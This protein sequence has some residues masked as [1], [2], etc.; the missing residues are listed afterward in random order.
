[1]FEGL[2]GLLLVLGGIYIV[3]KSKNIDI[4]IIDYISGLFR[5]KTMASGPTHIMFCFVD[6]YEPQWAIKDDIDTERKRVD[7]W[8]VDY[9]KLC[10]K[11]VD[12]DGKYPQHSFFYPEEEYREEHLSKLA[13]L[14]KS[15]YGEV[16]IHLHHDNDTSDNLR[17]TLAGFATLLQEQHGLLSTIPETKQPAYAFIH[18]NWCLCNARKDGRWCGVNDELVILK[19][20]GCYA[21]FTLP[22]APNES[23]TAKINS[24]YYAKD[25]SGQSKSHNS[26]VDVKVGGEPS[27]DLMVIQGPLTLNWKQRKF[28]FM[29]RIE[30]GDMRG[31]TPPSKERVDLWVN[32]NIH[33]QGRPEWL[34]VKIHTHGTQEQD[35]E[36]LLGRPVDEMFTYLEEKYNDGKRYVLHYVTAR[37]MYN[38]VKAAEAGL[39]GNPNNFRDYILKPP[40]YLS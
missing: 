18:G 20:T 36:T 22:A 15:G 27:G 5:K 32:A 24:I 9:P 12:A 28:G 10:A 35:M 4:W 26:G 21:D 23:Q 11:H 7:R 13:E 31:V 2:I 6:H 33:V 30:A 17:K 3:L 19:E 1:M 16:E 38:I 40:R 39:D 29:P 37:E 34:F 25:Q 14:C 8:M